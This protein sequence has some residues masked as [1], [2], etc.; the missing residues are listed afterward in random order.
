MLLKKT[1]VFSLMHR[2]IEI[3][4][5]YNYAGAPWKTQKRIRQCLK[6]WFRNDLMGMPGDEDGGGLSG[7]VVFSMMGF[8]PVTPGLPVYNLGSP[9][10]NDIRISLAGGKVLNIQAPLA[11][12]QAKYIMSA[13]IN[14]QPCNRP[15][16]NHEDIQN[17]GTIMLNM[18]SRH[19][20]WGSDIGAMPPSA[21]H[22]PHH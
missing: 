16:F 4:C 5:I 2:F 18:S 3:N 11:S 1:K 6:T 12:E 10:F 7:F 17:G 8:Y 14:G 19:T 15:W 22:Y 13:T 21:L 9:F 20:D